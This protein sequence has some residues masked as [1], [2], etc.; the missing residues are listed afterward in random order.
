MRA[1]QVRWLT[2]SGW[3]HNHLGPIRP[4]LYPPT[5]VGPPGL[6]LIVAAPALFKRFPQKL[7]D[8]IAYRCIRP[9]ATGWLFNRMDGVTI[10]TGCNV[11]SAVPSAQTTRAGVRMT[12]DDGTER[13]ADHVLLATGYRVDVRRH[14][15]LAPELAKSI[16]CT[17][18]YPQL[19]PGFESSVPGLHFLGAPAAISF[20]PLMRF[21]SGTG[22]TA[23]AL[24]RSLAGKKATGWL[25]A[26]S[27]ERVASG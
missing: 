22:Y 14:A 2:R 8:R 6:N 9:A 5:D 23:K 27:K 17:R 21:V 16:M 12:L 1:P 19:A 11:V 18:G 15:F 24:T 13:Y 10:S 25:V 3:L 20:G 4:L 7:Q 26:E